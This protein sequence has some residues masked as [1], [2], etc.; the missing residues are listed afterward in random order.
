MD[1]YAEFI[2]LANRETVSGNVDSASVVQ[3]HCPTDVLVKN[4][5][6]EEVVRIEDNNVITCDEQFFAAVKDSRKL[7]VIPDGEQCDIIING[8]DE[9]T[10]NYILQAYSAGGMIREVKFED[11]PLSE[12]ISY[13]TVVTNNYFEKKEVYQL[14]DNTGVT[15]QANYDTMVE[16]PTDIVDVVI[17]EELF[18]GFSKELIDKVADT[19]FNMKSSVD[20]SS[21][22]ISSEDIIALFS[23]VQKYYPIEY[24]ALGIADFTY[25]AVISPSLGIITKLR[26]YYGDEATLTTYQK[27]VKDLKAEIN[28]LVSKV[29]GMNEFEKALYIHDYIVMHCEYDLEL[30]D[31]MEANGGIVVGSEYYNEKYSEYSVLVNGTG[32]CGSYALAYR[33][34]LNAAGMDC[35]YLSSNAMSHAWNMVKIDGKWYHVDC[36]WDDPVPDTYGRARRTYFLRT[37]DEIMSLRHYSWIPGT[38]KATS[39]KYS[40]MRRDYDITQKYDNGN[41]YYLKLGKLM[42]SDVYGENEE[43]LCELTATTIDVD[44]GS[45]YYALGRYVYEY[46]V[47]TQDN[48]LVYYLSKSK[49]GEEPAKASLKNIYID[50]DEIDYYKSIIS[51]SKTKTINEKASLEKNKYAPITGITISQ[52]EATVDVF[53]TV[54][55]SAEI[56]TSGDVVLIDDVEVTW[57]SSNDAVATVDEN[58]KVKTERPGNVTITAQIL[59]YKAEC[60]L[61]IEKIDTELKIVAENDTVNVFENIK[62]NTEIIK[63]GSYNN[64]EI[65]WI[66]SD[67][68]VATVDKNGVVTG[69]NVGKA[70][71]C[72]Y[73]KNVTF[74]TGGMDEIE[75]TV[76]GD[77]SKGTINNELRWE[78]VL[79]EGELI[80]SGSG[81]MIDYDGISS[82]P[83]YKYRKIIKKVILGDGVLSIGKYAF[84]EFEN[85]ESISIPA[86]VTSINNYAFYGCIGLKGIIVDENNVKYLNDECGV[87]YDKQKSVI[88][89]YPAQNETPSYFLPNSVKIVSEYAFEYASHL[90]NINFGNSVESIG[91]YA[92]YNCND[93]NKIVIP[94]GVTS[95]GDYA[96][97][98]CSSLTSVTIPNSVTSIGKSAFYNCNDLTS[99]TIPNS[100]KIISSYAFAY[101]RSLVNITIP[102]SVTNIG[103]NAFVY[104]GSLENV[105]IPDSITSIGSYAFYG[106]NLNNVNIPKNVSTIGEAAFSNCPNVSFSV[107]SSNRYFTVDKFGVL[108]SKDMR[109]LVQYPLNS[110]V[111][112][113]IIPNG[114]TTVG[115]GAF[116]NADNLITISIPESTTKLGT[117]SIYLLGKKYA[118][119]GECDNLKYLI[120]GGNPKLQSYC[121]EGS[122]ALKKVLIK[123]PGFTF[124]TSATII[125]AGIPKTAVLYGHSGSK[126]ESYAKSKSQQFVSID[127]IPHEH[128]YFLM[129]YVEKTETTD[130][131]ELWEC[132]CGGYSYK[133]I[134]HNFGEAV[135]TEPTCG[136]DGSSIKICTVCGE[137]EIE[138]IPAA[139]KHN[140]ELTEKNGGDCTTA[141][142]LT[143]T[144]T[145]C[146]DSYTKEG[147]IDDGHKYV[148]TVVEPTCITK[149]Y[150]TATCSVCGETTIYDFVAPLGHK[151]TIRRIPATCKELSKLEYSCSRCDYHELVDDMDSGYSEHTYET[152]TTDATCSEEG[153]ISE[154][155]SICGDVRSSETIAKLEHDYKQT[156]TSPTCDKVGSKTYTCIVCGYT[157]SELISALGHKAVIDNSVAPT[158][159]SDGKTEGSHCSVCG[160]VLVKQQILPATG[161][162][163]ANKDGKCD[164]CGLDVEI[165]NVDVCNCLCHKIT[166]KFYKIIY[167]LIRVFWKIFKINRTCSCGIIHY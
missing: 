158:C 24:T 88:I 45:V 64:F 104:C 151:T 122:N 55:L 19:M 162:V 26:F 133:V 5:L 149:G 49:S 1:K 161:H 160:E 146:G 36:C 134:F 22:E 148:E 129:D 13:N 154:V 107:D 67:K 63:Q 111:A 58:G 38:Y 126:I 96:F 139:G 135:K 145:V 75:I 77:D 80:I 118:P 18:D 7:V 91:S 84:G 142:I 121:F 20:I 50:G 43:E 100:I 138:T 98:G 53:D 115:V 110:S 74:V 46:D 93:L 152:V 6:G 71:I 68:N 34:V 10:M 65:E 136:S 4:D 57:S 9:R 51:N 94:G 3:V 21:Y 85:L 141:P 116:Y 127:A 59:G 12:G 123:N 83:W 79:P 109:T 73:I 132:Y 143:Y 164:I 130:G 66:S 54:Q 128:D 15:Y 76:M 92:F 29:E 16:V 153:R 14:V 155:C 62:L 61:N 81:N 86:S 157:Y 159:I 33:A 11:V 165:D 78:V 27:R 25:K 60:K 125:D 101:C 89:K 108:Y 40:T 150:T 17:A 90:E 56:L 8:T 41:W 103:S 87:L 23:A 2:Y 37:D 28:S 113:Y 167:K 114:V 156:V 72:A 106:C 32:V 117:G 120:I 147:K 166:N 137:K 52:S 102:D 144:C 124:K 70:T 30:L 42:K 131:Y 105:T 99:I 39:S 44:N 82:V 95:I 31:Y 140:Y 112:I 69:V 47:E 163:D 48:S 119:F 35:L 97:Y